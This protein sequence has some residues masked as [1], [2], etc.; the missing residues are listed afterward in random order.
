[1]KRKGLITSLL[2]AFS[3]SMFSPLT[4][5]AAENTTSKLPTIVGESAITID[6]NTGEIIYY[7]SGDT[8]RYP[9]ST[10]KMM[11]ALLFSEKAKK[12]DEIPYNE[13]AKKQP[14]YSLNVNFKP[15]TVNDKMTAEDVMKALLM[16]SANDSAYMIADFLGSG[17]YHKFVDMMNDKAKELNLKNTHFANPNGLHDPDHYTTA[18]DL[19]VIAREAYKQPWVEEVMTTAKSSIKINNS[20][21]INLENRNKELGKNGNVGGKTGYT[22]QSGRCLATIYERDGRKIVGVVLKS[23]YDAQDQTVFNDMNKIMDYS[24]AAK[25]S[26]LLKAG[27]EIK[28]VDVS[29]KPLKFFGPTKTIQVPLVLQED[30]TYYDN[31]INKKEVTENVKLSNADAWSLAK[32]NS[33][34][35]LTVAERNYSKDYAVKANISTSELVKSSLGL[36]FGMAAAVIVV[37]ILLGLIISIVNRLKR[38]RRRNKNIF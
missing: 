21:V 19:S 1:M 38:K 2:L 9:A 6:Y 11:T 16:Y 14:E 34:V 17:D 31:E 30:V 32:D 15:M 27:S 35:K 13:D 26:T 22:S 23:N 3:I 4:V 8:K 36:Y 28:K 25:K 10:T 18:Y 12:S 5:K 24:F 20:T 33:S 37:L 29:Y 7:K